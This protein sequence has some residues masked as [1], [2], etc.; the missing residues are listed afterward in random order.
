MIIAKIVNSY[1]H[2]EYA[3]RVLDALDVK[4]PPRPRD[5]GFAGFISVECEGRKIV[6]VISNTQLINP[7]Y[8][9]FGPR[10]SSAAEANRLFSPDYLHDQGVLIGLLML[11]WLESDGQRSYG[12]HQTPELALPVHTS[13]ALLDAAD[14]RDFHRDKEGRL[15]LGYYTQIMRA[16][17][18]MAAALLLAIIDRLQLECEPVDRARLALLR[19]NLNWHQTLGALGQKH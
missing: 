13:V 11:G 18:A 7:D 15:R 8:G 14:A 5:Y 1:S 9:N 19:N 3:A 6:G 12:Q 10:L 16:G 4:Q 2:I 17:G